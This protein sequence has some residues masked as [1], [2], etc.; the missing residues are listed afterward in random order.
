MSQDLQLVLGRFRGLQNF[1]ASG[2]IGAG[3]ALAMNE[4]NAYFEKIGYGGFSVS[5]ND[6]LGYNDAS[7]QSLKTN[8]ILLGGPDAN[9][10]TYDVVQK[11]SLGIAFKE[12]DPRYP[13]RLLEP[14][15]FDSF[16]GGNHR[17][18]GYAASTRV[19]RRALQAVGLVSSRLW[20]IPVFVDLKENKV[21]EPLKEGDRVVMDC[22]LI[23]RA[24]NPFEP[25][26]TVVILCGSYGYGTW[27]AVQVAQSKQFVRQVPRGSGALECVLQLDV[28]RESPQRPRICFVRTL[29]NHELLAERADSEPERRATSRL[30]WATK[31]TSS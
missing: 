14:L 16:V 8:L 24:P 28:V 6:Q 25:S 9:S 13:N 23:I 17:S 19:A 18:D 30:P 20:R 5:Y 12:V 21:Y 10:L 1:E 2:V 22:G 4:L 11:L 3:D 26:K 7:G 27:A 15:I 29:P 31:I